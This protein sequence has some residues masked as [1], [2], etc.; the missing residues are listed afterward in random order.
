MIDYIKDDKSCVIAF[1]SKDTKGTRNTIQLAN[2]VKIPV[3]EIPYEVFE[4]TTELYEGVRKSIGGNFEL[5]WDNDMP[6]DLVKLEGSCVHITKY[7]KSIRCYGYKVNKVQAN[8]KDRNEFLSFLKMQPSNERTELISRCIEDFYEKCPQK[9]FDYVLKIPS[10]SSLNDEIIEQLN[11]YD[12]F[13]VVSLLKRPTNDLELNLDLIKSKFH[14]DYIE[15]FINYLQKIIDYNKKKDNFSISTFKPQYR[16]FI[17]P[18]ISFGN[19]DIDN[20][21]YTNILIVDDI[22]T[23][24][25]TMD[26]ILNLLNDLNFQGT[27]TMLT[28]IQNN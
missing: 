25:S 1:T 18:M 2:K 26:M 5:D 3:I 8:K 28:L 10:K 12:S 21:P 9:H 7:H 16:A 19:E 11:K 20:T 13:K 4:E 14:G 22:F 6:E 17:K 27:I 23:S 15:N 24:G